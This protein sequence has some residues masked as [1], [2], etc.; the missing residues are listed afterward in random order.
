MVFNYNMVNKIIEALPPLAENFGIIYYENGDDVHLYPIYEEE[1]EYRLR[2][3]DS[4]IR[5]EYGASKLV[6]T[7]PKLDGVVIKIPFSGY[8]STYEEDETFPEWEP[9]RYASGTKENDYCFA[10][11][12]KFKALKKQGL[13]CFVAKTFLYKTISTNTA[14]FI[15]EAITPLGYLWKPRIPS[16]E[17]KDLAKKI[18]E[19]R[20]I[21]I[22]SDWIANCLD[23]YHQSK[24]ER[25][26]SYCQ[27]VDLDI[28]GDMHYQNYGYR[29][30]GTPAI[31]DFSDFQD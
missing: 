7:S 15:Q 5:I 24:V 20:E 26:F 12:E 29:R 4:S 19:E 25:F 8:Y 27:D 30:N 18:K 3:V 22:S 31:L 16:K 14:V 23:Y 11:Y 1:F 17:S 10:E 13:D 9:F 6:I 28:L 2:Q 21:S